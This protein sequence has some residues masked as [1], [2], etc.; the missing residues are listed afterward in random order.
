MVLVPSAV[1]CETGHDVHHSRDKKAPRPS[2]TAGHACCIR[3]NDSARELVRHSTV[4]EATGRCLLVNERALLPVFMPL[5]PAA[6]LMERFPESLRQTLEAHEI[7][8][9]FIEF[10]NA[11]MIEGRYAK[12]ANRSVV[13]IMN[14][15]SFLAEVHRANRG[16]ND[17]NALAVKL[18]RTPCSPLYKR[19]TRPD[20]ELAALVAAWSEAGQNDRDGLV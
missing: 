18:S 8:A 15:F 1:W 5:A 12:T 14:E 17:L 13:G 10:E 3:A 16:I 2:A 9:E 4:L 11:A 20:Q 19:H 7:P 6:T